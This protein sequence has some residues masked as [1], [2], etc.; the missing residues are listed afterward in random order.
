MFDQYLIRKDSLQNVTEDGKVTGFKFAVRIADYRGCFLSL[1]N[2]YYI[3]VDGTE[4]PRNLQ[5]FEINGKA[6][7]SFEEIKT[8]CWEHWNYD[9][10]GW[11]YVTKEGGLSK[12]MHKI[13]LQQ[14]ILAQY[15]YMPWDEE[16]VKNPPVPGSGAGA[17]KTE[18]ICQFDLELQEC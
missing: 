10:E 7:R 14:S 18:T 5:R 3:N 9:D 15:G 17:G 11:V 2:G 1:H 13:G 8:A 16:W 6:P 12:G 4:Y